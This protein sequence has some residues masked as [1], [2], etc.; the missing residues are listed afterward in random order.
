MKIMIKLI[1]YFY[2]IHLTNLKFYHDFCLKYN[3]EN[4]ITPYILNEKFEL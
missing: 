1:T 3:V 4:L 2:L